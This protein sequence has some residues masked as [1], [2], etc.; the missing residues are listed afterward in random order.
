MM[1]NKIICLGAYV[2]CILVELASCTQKETYH[3]DFFEKNVT[4]VAEQQ[5]LQVEEINKT[6]KILYPRTIKDGGIYYTTI[7]DWCVGFF[8]ANLWMTYK[9]TGDEKWKEHTRDALLVES[10]ATFTNGQQ[11]GTRNHN[12]QRHTG[13][14]HRPI[15]RS[16]KLNLTDFRRR[17]WIKIERIRAMTAYHSKHGNQTYNVQPHDVPG[18]LFQNRFF[19][20]SILQNLRV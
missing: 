11:Q 3:N 4:F 5:K 18:L 8:P 12:E 9:L 17:A 1:S 19:I 13:T 15:S 2:C 6:G 10:S 16:P 7:R 14:K 20:K